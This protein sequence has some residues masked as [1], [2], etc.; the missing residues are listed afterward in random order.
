ML[1]K[2]DQVLGET[3]PPSIKRGVGCVVKPPTSRMLRD[4]MARQSLLI[5]L[6]VASASFLFAYGLFSRYRLEGKL[7]ASSLLGKR[8]S[9]IPLKDLRS[10]ED[11][12]SR[13]EKGDALLIYLLPGCEA[14]EKE[15]RFLIGSSIFKNRELQIYGVMLQD[16]FSAEQ[17]V[18]ANKLSFPILLDE[19]GR[20]RQRLDLKFFPA[21]LRLKDGVVCEAWFGFEPDEVKLK[22]HLFPAR[23]E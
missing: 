19:G 20:L 1:D 22:R 2:R 3:R 9:S 6:L 5:P 14:C 17:Y 8:V 10:G 21:N 7:D 13:L 15:L 4:G 16:R 23:C 11:H 12:A 18:E